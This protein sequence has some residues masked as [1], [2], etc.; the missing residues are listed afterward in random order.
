M[1]GGTGECGE[2]RL[3]ARDGTQAG[4]TR[5]GKEENTAYIVRDVE[6]NRDKYC[7]APAGLMTN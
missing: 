4:N 5:T 2:D 1:G 6:G 7:F 3:R